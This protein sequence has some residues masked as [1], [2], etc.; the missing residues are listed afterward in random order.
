MRKWKTSDLLPETP[1]YDSRLISVHT[2]AHTAITALESAVGY[3]G[4]KRRSGHWFSKLLGECRAA[5]VSLDRLSGLTTTYS[6]TDKDGYNVT[7]YVRPDGRVVLSTRRYYGDTR[8][9]DT[10]N[11]VREVAYKLNGWSNQRP[12]FLYGP[13]VVHGC[14]WLPGFVGL[15]STDYDR[16]VRWLTYA[17]SKSVCRTAELLAPTLEASQAA[18]EAVRNDDP[19]ALTSFENAATIHTIRCAAAV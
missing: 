19:E 3:K 8:R 1:G 17:L 4:P 7:C 12:N 2:T 10:P 16:S 13:A 6:V 15:T 14:H 11:L 5:S 18:W 9:D